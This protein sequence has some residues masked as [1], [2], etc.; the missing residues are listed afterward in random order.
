MFLLVVVRKEFTGVRASLADTLFLGH[1]SYC[2]NANIA[3]GVLNFYAVTFTNYPFSLITG[4][5]SF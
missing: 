5:C 1:M 3:I 4:N 2:Q